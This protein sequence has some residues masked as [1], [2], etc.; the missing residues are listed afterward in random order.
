MQAE[1]PQFIDLPAEM[2]LLGAILCDPPILGSVVPIVTE[3]DF[4]IERHRLLYRICRDLFTEATPPDFVSVGREMRRIGLGHF[5]PDYESYLA[6]LMASCPWVT[7]APH[8]AEA[9]ADMAERRRFTQAVSESV[10]NVYRGG[11]VD[12]LIGET[13]QHLKAVSRPRAR[14]RYQHIGAVDDDVFGTPLPRAFFGGNFW[15]LDEIVGG[16]EPGQMIA[17]G[18]RTSVGKTAT[19]L[20]LLWT[21]AAVQGAPVG[22]ISLEMTARSLRTRLLGH[23]SH[24][25][26]AAL[27]RENRQ[28]TPE[29]QARLDEARAQMEYT[30]F[31]IDQDTE[32]RLSS[33]LDRIRSMVTE[34]R[35]AVVG[36]DYLQ[37]LADNVKGE[38]RTQ[39][40]TRITGAIKQL[41]MELGIPIFCLAQLNRNIEQRDRRDREPQ[42][43]DFKDTG[44]IEQDCDVAMLLHV[45]RAFKR[46]HLNISDDAMLDAVPRTFIRFGVAKNR[47]GATGSVVMEYVGRFTE[48]CPILPEGNFR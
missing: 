8:Y 24:V 12:A 35:I 38:N 40:L 22:I 10:T 43:S 28:P 32:R 20:Q 44:A 19:L 29:E 39:E 5:A 41:A 42:L 6:E 30:P 13:H 23:L 34:Q 46:K 16:V 36:I 14:G 1:M 11:D 17:I 48:F 7:Y 45:D 21:M 18:A 37:L 25:N 3:D 15:E 27:K 26:I 9:V 31:Y 33:V 4:G 2:A 47:N